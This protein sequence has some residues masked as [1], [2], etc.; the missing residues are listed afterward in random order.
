[1]QFG[2]FLQLAFEALSGICLPMLKN[3]SFIREEGKKNICQ[4]SRNSQ[5]S[6]IQGCVWSMLFW[7]R[8][9]QCMYW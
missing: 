6:C 4:A 5:P 7:P 8:P 9:A 3:K 2:P 1:M